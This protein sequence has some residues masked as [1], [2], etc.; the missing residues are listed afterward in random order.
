M[1]IQFSSDRQGSP[2]HDRVLSWRAVREMTGLSRTTAW[3]LQRSGAFPRPVRLSPGRVG[4]REGEIAAWTAGLEPRAAA[5]APTSTP[6]SAPGSAGLVLT[7]ANAPPPAAEPLAAL[8]SRAR[9]RRKPGPGA[10]HVY[11]VTGSGGEV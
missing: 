1:S 11:A 6:E 5:P 8:P 7:D 9:V 3:R 10:E 2:A 4:W